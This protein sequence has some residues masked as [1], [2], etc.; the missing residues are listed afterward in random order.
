MRYRYA[1][2]FPRCTQLAIAGL[3]G[4]L[5]I[6]PAGAAGPLKTL[7]YIF[8]AA[9]TG[10]DPAVAR[11]L[12]TGHVT[13]AIFETLY[14]YDYLARPVLL[15]PHAASGLPEVSNDGKT[16]TIRLKKGQYFTPDPAFKGKRRELT[17]AD[18]VYSW[19]RLFDPSWPRRTAGCSKARW[20]AWTS[21]PRTRKK[22]ASSTT[23][24]RWRG[25]NWWT[26]IRCAS[27]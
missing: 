17:M 1:M 15:V 18:Y 2:N 9:E 13:Q 5:A 3:V 19:K 6:L 23:T 21:W 22:Q 26:R 12:Y 24:K 4:V 11:D 27:T 20:W 25:W 7:R 14:S 8:P 10:F 16:Y